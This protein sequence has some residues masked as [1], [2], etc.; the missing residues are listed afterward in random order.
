MTNFKKWNIIDSL[1]SLN[2]LLKENEITCTLFSQPSC[3]VCASIKPQLQQVISNN[4]PDIELAYV[5]ISKN[6]EIA[7]KHTIFSIPVLIIFIDSKEHIRKSRIINIS[8]LSNELERLIKL[9]K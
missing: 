9:Y 6:P 4:F 3:G 7:G 1:E 5:D 2:N 8:Q